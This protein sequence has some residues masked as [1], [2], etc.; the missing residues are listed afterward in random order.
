MPLALLAAAPL[1]AAG[2][3]NAYLLSLATRAA[4]YALAAVSL[5]VVVGYGGLVSL[6]HAA[7]V[8]IG[9]Y[10]L[11]ILSSFGL[12]EA[13]LSLPAAAAA[14]A[15]FA[16]PTG[17]IA[18][19]ARGV[20]FLMLTL[21]FSQMAYFAAGSLAD[22]G[23]DDGMPLDRTPPL[24]GTGLLARPFALHLLAL[25]LLLGG[26]LGAQALG[27]SRFGRVLRAAREN[28]GRVAALGFD[29]RRVRLAAYVLAAAAARRG[30]VAAG[31]RIRLREPGAAR[32]AGGRRV[33]GDGHPRRRPDPGRHG[34]RRG[35]AGRRRGGV[36]RRQRAWAR[37]PRRP[38]R[39]RRPG[40]LAVEARRMTVLA[41]E[42]LRKSFGALAVTADVSLA[43]RAG[44]VHALIGPN[45]AGKTSLIAQ[46]AG[47]LAPDAGRVRL[48]GADITALPP[49]RRARRG[50]ARTFQVS[51][52]IPGLSAL[53]NV[54]LAVQAH[55][56]RPLAPWR[57]AAGDPALEG[58]AQRPWPRSG[59]PG[60][61]AFWPGRSRTASSGRWRSARRWRRRRAACCSTNRSPAWGTRRAR[62]SWTCCAA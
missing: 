11:L 32:L 18:L 49:Y 56:P 13:A 35:R 30:G 44:E 7:F 23:G 43:V 15:L 16:W 10:A 59:W 55:A 40:S 31:R 48:D 51:A 17:W 34:R 46:L 38:A 27:A 54:A 41:A 3:G 24:L 5:Q 50:L 21:A 20:G 60:A 4:V 26:V 9:A 12:D 33:A 47:T 39:A 58:P 14:A 52:L 29:V 19:R 45:G 42:G 57:R 36:C 53:E 25:L 2:T 62:G 37:L 8:G 6:G 1:I 61:R 28:A 22:Y